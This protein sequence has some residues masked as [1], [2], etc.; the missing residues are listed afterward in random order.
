MS[1]DMNWSIVNSIATYAYYN[2]HG[3]FK[4]KDGRLCDVCEAKPTVRIEGVFKSYKYDLC[5]DC[6]DKVL[7][8]MFDLNDH[9][10]SI[11]KEYYCKR[12]RSRLNYLMPEHEWKD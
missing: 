12:F 9:K 6:L 11:D 4:I 2:H 7:M 1:Y 3:M 5:D 8:K 10:E